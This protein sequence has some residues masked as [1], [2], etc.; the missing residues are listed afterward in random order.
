MLLKK[1][2]KTEC[3]FKNSARYKNN[4]KTEKRIAIVVDL[5]VIT[6]K[7]SFIFTENEKNFYGQ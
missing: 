5:R 2:S 3:C 7:M 1:I 6:M 4:Y